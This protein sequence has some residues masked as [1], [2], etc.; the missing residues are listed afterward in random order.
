[1][2]DKDKFYF[3]DKTADSEEKEWLNGYEENKR[4]DLIF[5]KIL[6]G[7]DFKNKLVYDAGCGLGFFSE[8]LQKNGAEVFALDV[9]LNLINKTREKSGAFGTVGSI[10][11]T[12]FKNNKFDLIIC[13]EVIEHTPNPMGAIPELYRVLKPGGFLVL[14]VPNRFWKFAEIIARKTHIRPYLGYENFVGY[15]NLRKHI[16]KAGFHI[17][18]QFGFNLFPLFYKPFFSV[19][20]YFDKWGNC[21]G[22]IMVNIAITATK[23]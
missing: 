13:S 21:I 10:L 3:W 15:Y 18:K 11:N 16:L 19:L 1:M 8:I 6:M 2:N 12:P 9:G 4:I 23:K 22:P 17:E 7:Y 5:N 20:D 14:T